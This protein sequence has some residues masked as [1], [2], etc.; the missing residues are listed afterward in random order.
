VRLLVL[1]GTKF[2]GRA[3]VEAALARGHD[4][5]LLNRGRT[6]PD[7]FPEATKLVGDRTGDLAALAAGEWDAVID[8]SG[9]VPHVV[10]ASAELLA[11]RVGH[12]VFVSSISVYA[13]LSGPRSEDDALAELG[14]AARDELAVDY[15][16]YGALK[17]LCE[18]EVTRLYAGRSAV[19]RA[20]LIVGAHDPT[21]RFNYWPHRVARGGDVLVPGPPER[22]VQFVDVRDL[23]SWL[24][25]LGE[26]RTAGTFNA[27]RP[28]VSWGELFDGCARVTGSGARPVWVSDDFLLEQGVEQWLELPLWIADPGAP[29]MH[30]VAVGRA[31]AA[32]LVVRP[33]DETIRAALAEAEPTAEAG[34]APERETQLLAALGPVGPSG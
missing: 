6:N 7:L 26:R 10:R 20:G 24:V 8:P 13:D 4:V 19:V 12:Y 18:Q 22:Q 29:G 14:E 17:A 15:S 33:L 21:G 31:L 27:T 16:N 9:Y 25:D 3:A 28:G 34:L 2:L 23:G 11:D 32:G 1:G 5:T 30:Q